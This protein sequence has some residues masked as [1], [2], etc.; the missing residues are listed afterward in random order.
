MGLGLAIVDTIVRQHGGAVRIE[1]TPGGGAT[2][3]I[4]LP[5]AATAQG[6]DA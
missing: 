5:A 1:D 4:A 6:G 3:V 2:F